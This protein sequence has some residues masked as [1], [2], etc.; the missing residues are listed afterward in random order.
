VASSEEDLYMP[1]NLLAFAKC[2]SDLH[3]NHCS[4][5]LQLDDSLRSSLFARVSR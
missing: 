2:G 4:S 5:Q 3:H 1:L